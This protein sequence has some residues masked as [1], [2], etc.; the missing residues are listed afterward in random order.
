MNVKKYRAGNSDQAMRMIRRTHGADVAILDCYSVPGGVEVVVS[1]D[2]IGSAPMPAQSAG[3][4]F[5][6]HIKALLPAEQKAKAI[7]AQLQ[8][9][10]STTQPA[11][12]H[13]E[14]PTSKPESEPRLAWSQDQELL[15]MKQ[16]LAAMKSMLLGQLKEQEWQ[17]TE[18]AL[19][20]QSELQRFM[21]AIDLDP[22]LAKTLAAEIPEHEDPRLQREMLKAL[23]A[24]KLPIMTPPSSGA[25]ALLGPQ[26]A[27]KT[28]TIAKLASQHVLRHGR[29][30][31]AILTTDI[32]RVGAQQ[33]LQA[34]GHLLQVP[35]YS[36]TDNEE[37]I[38]T[39]RLLQNK[40]T[41]LVDTTG[42]SFRNKAGLAELEALLDSMPGLNRYLVLPADSEAYVQSE[43][44]S[45]YSALSPCG[46]VL[47]RLD[48]SMRLGASLS[49][50]IQQRLPVVW[51]SNGPK[52][53]N[54]LSV[55]DAEKLANLAIRMAR[56]FE[57]KTITT[58]AST[59]T[60]K[61][62]G[63]IDSVG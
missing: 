20:L 59:T 17:Q 39:F 12:E 56:P 4:N 22:A 9:Q 8:Q 50:L 18:R 46:A 45:A 62:A 24:T 48:E 33:Q 35:V 60:L 49:N 52:V 13:A 54:N 1:L 43:I 11:S 31:I 25:I 26:G 5:K 58:P 21:E 53:P 3:E 38:K 10:M 16:E 30:D 55:A 51:C 6:S 29:D 32:Q 15:S 41:V 28:T 47:S 34:F 27:G 7:Q 23:L 37:A 57:Q 14:P 36:A 63:A 61:A 42:V 44:I 40:G 2:E 19:P